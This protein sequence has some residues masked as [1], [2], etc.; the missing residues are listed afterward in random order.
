MAI[1]NESF[2]NGTSNL[3][4]IAQ[5][6]NDN[7]SQL[8]GIMLLVALFLILFITLLTVD[9]NQTFFVTSFVTSLIGYMLFLINLISWHVFIIVILLLAASVF[10]LFSNKEI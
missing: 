5:G 8:F 3:V 1:Y 4:T 7:S 6:I 10:K 9:I 2:M